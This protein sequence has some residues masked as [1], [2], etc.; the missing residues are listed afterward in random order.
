[1]KIGI[2]G[3]TFNPVH[4]GHLL[5]AQYVKDEFALDTILFVPSKT[6]VHKHLADQTSADDR[7]R[8][9]ELAIKGNSSFKVSR[10]EIDRAEPSYTILTVKEIAGL[11]PEAELYLILGADSFYEIN[12]WKDHE[13]ILAGTVIIV[14]RREGDFAFSDDIIRKGKKIL[15]SK[16]PIIEI[17]SS[18]VRSRIKRN[19][20]V[21]YYLPGTVVEYINSKG[22]YKN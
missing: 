5:N 13:K 18:E 9:L 11:Y 15:F 22:L 20:P 12:I 3:G 7:C 14:L 2:Y 6:P 8:M 16:N 4:I 1:M 17:S 21:D 10:I 19:S